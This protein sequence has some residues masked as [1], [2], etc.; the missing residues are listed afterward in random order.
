MIVTTNWSLWFWRRA[1]RLPTPLRCNTY[2]VISQHAVKNGRH[3]RRRVCRRA[4]LPE[5]ASTLLAGFRG[6][7]KRGC[8][9]K[10]SQ[11]RSGVARLHQEGRGRPPP[12]PRTRA[13]CPDLQWKNL[14]TGHLVQSKLS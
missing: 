3:T 11:W 14:T 5:H 7:L 9:T 1:R 13:P 8:N 6:V 12:W 10:R 4:L 2:W